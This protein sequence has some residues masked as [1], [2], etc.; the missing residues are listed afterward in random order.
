MWFPRFASHFP[1]SKWICWLP[2][3]GRRK[4]PNHYILHFGIRA[5]TNGSHLSAVCLHLSAVTYPVRC[6]M[7]CGTL[8]DV[9][10]GLMLCLRGGGV[11]CDCRSEF[12]PSTLCVAKE[13]TVHWSLW[14]ITS[15]IQC[16]HACRVPGSESELC[17]FSLNIQVQFKSNMKTGKKEIYA[18]MEAPIKTMNGRCHRATR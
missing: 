1:R 17:L 2:H 14:D 6:R 4:L 5:L 12:S 7:S 16:P 3:V 18:D 10:S 13:Q 9:A 8:L 11:V 15:D